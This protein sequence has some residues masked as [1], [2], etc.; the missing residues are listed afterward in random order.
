MGGTYMYILVI[1]LILTLIFL[2]W[3][4]RK[5]RFKINYSCDDGH[6]RIYGK[7][8]NFRICKDNRFV[9]HIVDG[10]IVSFSDTTIGRETIT[11]GGKENGDI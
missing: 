7:K 6:F 4:Y 8:D 9:F 1:L 2:L 3:N 10:E 5:K 11:Y